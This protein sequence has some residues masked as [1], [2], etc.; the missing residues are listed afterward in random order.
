MRRGKASSVRTHQAPMS[1][2]MATSVPSSWRHVCPPDEVRH[3]LVAGQ[4]VVLV[5]P[6]QQGQRPSPKGG[7]S[8]SPT[9]SLPAV[10]LPVTLA[11]TVQ[12]PSA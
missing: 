9:R 5:E 10:M 1:S 3:T 6:A 12:V 8:R 4:V 7:M 11:G 2:F